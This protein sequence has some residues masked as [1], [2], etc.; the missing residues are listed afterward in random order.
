MAGGSGPAG[1]G[2][3]PGGGA[4]GAVPGGL[5][6]ALDKAAGKPVTGEAG[7]L[8]E[9]LT[10]GGGLGRTV[11][12]V[13]GVAG[14]SPRETTQK[15]AKGDVK[16]VAKDVGG[17]VKNLPQTV[18]NAPQKVKEVTKTVPKPKVTVP[19][20]V[21]LPGGGSVKTGETGKTGP[22][23]TP[24]KTQLPVPQLPTVQLAPLP[25]TPLTSGLGL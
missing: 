21:K 17:T 4:H 12:S 7:R 2:G 25:T 5:G 19:N 14:V 22:S 9:Q 1:P 20:K 18:K 15:L 10:Q 11:E 3:P 24:P 6:G 8:M 13:G 23:I 16:G